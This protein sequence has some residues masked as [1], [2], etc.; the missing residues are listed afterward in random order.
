MKVEI[1]DIKKLTATVL[2]TNTTNKKVSWKSNSA[3][4]E[5]IGDG[6]I[7]G[8]KTG[9]AI[10]TATTTDGSNLSASCR[11]TV[12]SNSSGILLGDVDDN[13]FVN[14]DDV[15]VLIDYLLSGYVTPFNMVNADLDA[16]SKITIN[17]MTLLIDLLLR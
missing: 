3:N 1:G 15:V 17:D 9:T 16:D 13:G 2:P 8:V 5:V 11:V 10:I 7:K 14:I 12:I 4:V 6:Y